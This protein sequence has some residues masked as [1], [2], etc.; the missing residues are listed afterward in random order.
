MLFAAL[1]GVAAAVV[2]GVVIAVLLAV[3]LCVLRRMVMLLTMLRRGRGRGRR[4]RTMPYAFFNTFNGRLGL[5]HRFLATI[6]EQSETP[7]ASFTCL[8]Y[9]T[10]EKVKIVEI[11]STWI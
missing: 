10:C 8:I 1:V 4:I 11:I 7:R 2:A 3:V 9:H 5:L 6:V